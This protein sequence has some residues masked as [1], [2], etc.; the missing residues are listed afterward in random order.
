[1]M[2]SLLKQRESI[3]EMKSSLTELA[4]EKGVDPSSTKEQTKALEEHIA[5]IDAQIAQTQKQQEQDT[6]TP[7][8]EVTHTPE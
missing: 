6:R 1:M 2:E 8:K 3:Q 5:N 4:L 7:K